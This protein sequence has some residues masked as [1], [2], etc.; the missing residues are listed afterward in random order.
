MLSVIGAD[1]AGLVDALAEVVADHGGSWDRSQMTELA[2]VFAG[3]VMVRIPA[4][5]ATAWRDALEPLREQ[6]LLDVTLRPAGAS[7]EEVDTAPTSAV[8]V[9]GADRPGIVHEVSHALAAL[10]VGIVDLR[11]WTASAPMAGERL[12]HASAAVRLPGGVTTGDLTAALEAL[13]DDLMVDL[14][15]PEGPT[16]SR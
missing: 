15:E 3:V 8:T 5:R 10:G 2:G 4:G 14:G 7:L 12:F 11:T 13:A 1:R 6:G 9:V 16:A